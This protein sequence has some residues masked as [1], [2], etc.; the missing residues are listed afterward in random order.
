MIIYN[1]LSIQ[2]M[3]DNDT[4]NW[5]DHIITIRHNIKLIHLTINHYPEFKYIN[6][7]SKKTNDIVYNWNKFLKYWNKHLPEYTKAFNIE[8]IKLILGVDYSLTPIYI[9]SDSDNLYIGIFILNNDIIKNINTNNTINTIMDIQEKQDKQDFQKLKHSKNS[10]SFLSNIEP[11]PLSKMKLNNKY[12][13]IYG[14]LNKNSSDDNFKNK[15]FIL[16]T[17]LNI[18][19]KYILQNSMNYLPKLEINR[20]KMSSQNLLN[21]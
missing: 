7:N 2:F 1:L 6:S 3:A 9:S 21:P 17:K 15:E 4:I 10:Y 19:I 8:F 16:D 20:I 12:N 11:Y 14:I 5:K 18:P 13:F